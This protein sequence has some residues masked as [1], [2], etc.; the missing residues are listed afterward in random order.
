ML[1]PIKSTKNESRSNFEL[2]YSTQCNLIRKI[3]LKKYFKKYLHSKGKLHLLS[4][5]VPYQKLS[6]CQNFCY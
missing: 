3:T 6:D 1:L 5:F 2:I 4:D